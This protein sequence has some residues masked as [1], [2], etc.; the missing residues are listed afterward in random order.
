[1][2]HSVIDVELQ[3]NGLTAAHGPIWLGVAAGAEA[4]LRQVELAWRHVAAL[5]D[6]N[7]VGAEAVIERI[8]VEFGPGSRV[9]LHHPARAGPLAQPHA[10]CDLQIGGRRQDVGA[11]FVA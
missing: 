4:A 10:E 5:V 11:A 2:K 7:V 1:M 9:H 3:S 6:P 8:E